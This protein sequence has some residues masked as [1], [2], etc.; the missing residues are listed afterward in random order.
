MGDALA[1]FAQMK[2]IS[3]CLVTRVSIAEANVTVMNVDVNLV[4]RIRTHL[5][6]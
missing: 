3:A 1:L 5:F 2:I 6:S 4:P